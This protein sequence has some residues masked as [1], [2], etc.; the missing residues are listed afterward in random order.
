M[1][2]GDADNTGKYRVTLKLYRDCDS[3]GPALDRTA[4]IL[5][6]PFGSNTPLSLPSDVPRESYQPISLQRPDPCISNPPRV[7]YEIAYYSFVVDLPYTANG[8]TIVYQRCCRIDDIFNVINSRNAGAT[9]TTLIP[10]NGLVGTAPINSTPVFNTS[11]T[12]IIC[13]N[14]YFKYDFGAT[15]QDRDQLEYIFTNAYIGGETSGGQN[16]A[17]DPAAP[18]FSSVLYNFG[19]SAS[20]PLGLNVNINPRTG[21]ISGTAPVAGIYVVT[22]GVI[23][24]RNGQVINV[25]RKDLHLKVANCQ[26]AAA[27]LEETTPNCKDLKVAFRNLSNS[28]L[29]V[30]YDW[31]F[32]VPNS[33]TDVSTDPTPSFVYPSS[34]DYTVR[35]ITNK[36]Q[37]CSDSAF[38]LVKVYPGFTVDFTALET[39]IGVPFAFNDAS[40]TAFGTLRSWK[41]DFGNSAENGDTAATPQAN[42]VYGQEG[43][44]LVSLIVSNS[45]GC[46]DTARRQVSVGSRPVLNLSND[47]LICAVDTLQLRATGSG[48]YRWSPNYMINNV[49]ARDPLVSPDVPTT[50][51][52]NVELAPGCENID[53]VFVDVRS[54]VSLRAGQDTTICFG[55]SIFLQ[56]RSDGVAYQWSPAATVSSPTAKESWA[57]PT[58]TTRYSVV[59]TIGKCQATD[60]F[61]VNTVPYPVADAGADTVIC[62]GDAAVLGARGGE[63]YFWYPGNTL[64]DQTVQSPV[65][66]PFETTDYVVAV[67]DDRGCPKPFYDTVRVAVVQPVPAYAGNDT[68]MVIGQPLQLQAS[69]GLFYSWSPVA[70]L[71]SPLV[72]DPIARL[73]SDMSFVVRVSTREGCY[74]LDTVQVKVY[75]TPPELFVPTAFTPN[76]DGLNDRLKPIPVGI[77]TL[78]YFRVYNRY[79]ELVFSTSEIGKGWNGVYKGRDQ[80]NE[81]FVWQAVG[82]DYLGNQ[83]Y[84]KGQTTLIR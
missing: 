28:P 82:I 66:R 19:F 10:G 51:Y 3:D 29:I 13:A 12:V 58:G 79:G 43:S 63:Q 60:G 56:P 5:F 9:Y 76:G 64:N 59:A 45:V 69:G 16:T 80:G 39:C 70:F 57:R 22:V 2:A 84:R 23:E 50:Y 8:Y 67:Y 52:V 15:D 73:N 27:E 1:G 6:Y 24:K 36:G 34:G 71:D 18:P 30:S 11:D 21:L 25:H 46:V 17:P 42:Y 14:N 38:T 68:V 49:N 54:F 55:D 74:A 7:C 37:E 65:A 75:K 48:Q 31:D 44:Y 78:V 77:S 62:F 47:T 32:G 40:T 20:S 26:T 35:L 61:V 41:W 81:S 4:K 72:A 83:V 33:T 53:S